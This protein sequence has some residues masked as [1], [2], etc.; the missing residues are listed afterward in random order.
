MP[1]V[2]KFRPRGSHAKDVTIFAGKIVGIEGVGTSFIH[3][4][5]DSGTVDIG[6]TNGLLLSP[7]CREM[8]R[9]IRMGNPETALK[10]ANNFSDMLMKR[11]L[12]AVEI[13]NA[14]LVVLKKLQNH[15]G[16][17]DC[18]IS[19]AHASALMTGVVPSALAENLCDCVWDLCQEGD[20]DRETQ[21]SEAMKPLSYIDEQS[22]MGHPNPV[23]RNTTMYFAILKEL[24]THL[25]ALS[26]I[27]PLDE[28]RIGIWKAMLRDIPLYM[29]NRDGAIREW[30]DENLDDFYM[31]RHLSHLYPLFPGE[32]IRSGD[33]LF[34]ACAKAVGLRKHRGLSGW[35]MAHMS[36]IYVRL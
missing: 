19:E 2:V 24:L 15:A 32:E 31:H 36:A 14:Y 11:Q 29:V 33:A 12:P 3:T 20:P 27:V 4:A 1:R 25:L 21:T 30:M 17:L 23:V 9:A 35:S 18:S 7:E 22:H 5:G 28:A 26:E 8:L 10:Y 34:D 6:M 16:E 13:K